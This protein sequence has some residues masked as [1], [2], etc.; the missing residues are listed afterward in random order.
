MDKIN[1]GV[2]GLGWWGKQMSIFILKS[3]KFS[4]KYIY[5][6]DLMK[7]KEIAKEFKC[8]TVNSV[9]DLLKNKN[10]ECVFIFSPNEFHLEHATKVARAGKHVFLEK[11]I[12]NN[13]NDAK[14]IA[15]V[16][17]EN[18]VNLA[19]GHNVRHY[20]LFKKV[21]ELI[22]NGLIGDIVYIDGN[23]SRPIG[24]SIGKESWRFYSSKCNG[25]P[26]IQMAIH[27]LD[28]VR[29]VCG[30]SVDEV[31]KI[32]LKKILKTENDES[33]GL[34]IR[35]N[36]NQIL[37]VFSSYVTQESFYLNFFGTK[38][39]L[40]ADVFNGLYIQRVGKF[41]KGK[42]SFIKN[43]PE[44][45]EIELF[46]NSI[47]LKKVSINPSVREAIENVDLIERILKQKRLNP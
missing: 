43:K 12:A 5:D 14:K 24:Y 36:K 27:L 45:E 25:G 9:D 41:K 32:S 39:T 8:A 42:I 10:I 2:I 15:K 7:A 16:C 33:F 21:K 44:V 47:K 20:N 46:F 37:H 18:G 3:H 38:G 30:L 13:T 40:Y 23:R 28:T 26:L 35:F 11:P 1:C 29:F 22:G 17:E 4:I 31:K 34:L 19:V 6:I